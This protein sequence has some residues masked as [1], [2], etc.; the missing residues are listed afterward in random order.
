M[1]VCRVRYDG[2]EVEGIEDE[3]A[4][5][6]VRLVMRYG[7][8][9]QCRRQSGSALLHEPDGLLIIQHQSQPATF[10]AFGYQNV[11]GRDAG[12]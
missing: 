4:I 10:P 2:R 5:H 7:Q 9:Q 11:A 3:L 12:R 6:A 8:R 1:Q